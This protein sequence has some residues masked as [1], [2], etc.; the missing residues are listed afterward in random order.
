[1]KTTARGFR[2]L[3]EGDLPDYRGT[4]RHLRHEATG[5]EVLHVACSDPECLFAFSFL[6]PPEDDSG[7]SHILEHSVL[8]GS[9]RYPLRE[10]FTM[11]MKGSVQ[12]FLNAFTYPDRTVYPAASCNPRDFLNLLDVYGDA[13]FFP[14]LREETFRQ[15]GWRL[16]GVREGNLRLS[17]VVYNEMKGA[18]ASADSVAGDWSYRS[19]FPDSAY[20]RESGGEPRAIPSL[21]LE[22]LRAY[23]HRWYHPSNCRIF[24]YGDI[25]VDAC[26]ELIG[27]RFLSAFAAA[28]IDAR[29][30]PA[31]RWREPRR[32]EKTYA[33]PPG[34]PA[35][36][37][38]TAL[39]SWRGPSVADQDDVL[40][41]EV[42]AEVLVGTPGSPLWKALID[43]GLGE[44]LSP[45]SGLETELAEVV[46]TVGLRGTEPDRA[47]A[48]ERVIFGT[49]DE[50]ASRG[51]TERLVESTINR[52][53]FR[54]REIRGNGGPYSLRLLRRLLRGWSHGADPIASLDFTSA[55]RR[56]RGKLDGGSGLLVEKLKETLR[57]NPHRATVIVRP[58]PEQ[59]ERE[60]AEER[61][62]VAR[63]ESGW[64][65]EERTR[66]AAEED[67]FNAFQAQVESPEELAVVPALSRSDL[68]PGIETIPSRPDSVPGAAAVRVH[69]LFANGV[70]SVD[71][72][73]PTASLGARE[74]LLL[75]LLGRIVCGAGLPGTS[76]AEVA[77][78]LQ[79]VTGGFRAQLE[80][81]GVVGR[82]G[83]TQHAMFHLKAL[84]LSVPE[85]FELAGR[86]LA[87]ADFHDR[88]RIRDLVLELCG[89]LKSAILPSGSQFVA[90]RASA[91]LS[92][93]AALEER[94][95]GLSQ[96]EF[97]DALAGS[98][99]SRLDSLVE[100]LERLRARL[101]ARP[102]LVVNLTGETEG[103]ASARKALAELLARLP[104][105]AAAAGVPQ[106]GA[107]GPMEPGVSAESLATA[108]SVGYGCRAIA[109]FGFGDR[110]SP[111]T[112]VLAHLLTTGFLWDVVRREGGA[113]GAMAWQRPLEGLF[114]MSSYRDPRVAHSLA[115]FRRGLEMAAGGTLEDSEVERAVV[116][117]IG[118]EDRPLYPAEKGFASL[119]R[120]LHGVTD[121][122]R[123]ERRRLMLACGKADLAEAAR[124][125]LEGFDRGCSV[126]LAG[127]AMIEEAAREI[128]AL[129]E[130]IR[131]VPS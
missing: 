57:A 110:R 74:S 130:I 118:R 54:N 63:M 25:P 73:F 47:E 56:L 72:C 65:P 40:A 128:P 127:R 66:L 5:C 60:A 131:E 96:L 107:P 35:E 45:V 108:A 113:Y 55:M 27:T 119:Q 116:G 10:P 14:L 71:L 4:A 48:M 98:I 23:H 70:V 76:Y 82:E 37:R 58:D 85:A 91:H 16:E 2:L 111:P 75:P 112:A 94:W 92:G 125:L 105:A 24:L 83:V 28:S 26:L 22:R 32:L 90:L 19:L 61:A 13:V 126:V 52:I 6:T 59:G 129:G 15:E 62:R 51:L 121:G 101:L 123:Q 79:R 89:D 67:A 3:T 102:G 36:R 100:E 39:V 109:G 8:S 88:S 33:I 31:E 68:R 124:G 122:M 95:H 30:P 106:G 20:G 93:A 44:D 46:F 120:E 81:G 99:D 43:S 18:T 11:L 86:L 21:T 1:M 49:L 117:T 41:L 77:V 114:V 42:L 104:A 38:S 69:E 29:I 80:A 64:S 87:E 84:A 17:G 115:A 103:L 97:I 78:E 50:L 34:A 12:T 7:A 9:R 53:E